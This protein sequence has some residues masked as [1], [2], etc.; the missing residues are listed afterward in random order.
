M[1]MGKPIFAIALYHSLIPFILS[2]PDYYSTCP[3]RSYQFRNNHDPGE[4]GRIMGLK[5][6]YSLS[7]KKAHQ[8]FLTQST[9]EPIKANFG[10]PAVVAKLVSAVDPWLCVPTFRWV[11][12]FRNC[13]CSIIIYHLEDKICWILL[14]ESYFN[15]HFTLIVLLLISTLKPGFTYR[16]VLQ[17]YFDSWAV[18][19]YNGLKSLNYK[20]TSWTGSGPGKGPWGRARKGSRWNKHICGTAIFHDVFFC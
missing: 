11:C 3:K 16:G 10:N 12:L 7:S 9:S 20:V 2:S 1:A 19:I 5:R 18:I 14:Y 15:H 13:F 17:P 6:W 8:C 4:S